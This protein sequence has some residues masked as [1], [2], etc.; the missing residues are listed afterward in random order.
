MSDKRFDLS[1]FFRGGRDSLPLILA[2]VPFGIVYGAMAQS[3]GLTKWEAMS[4]SVFVF[5]GSSQFIAVTLLASAAAL[6]VIA[7]TVFIVNLRHLLYAASLMPTAE[8]IP[9]LLRVPMAFWLTD[10]TYAV[11]SN[12]LRGKFDDGK[13]LYAYYIGSAVFMYVNWQLCTWIGITVGEKV[14]DMTNWGLDVAMVVAFIG[15]VVPALQRAA[16][17]ACAATSAVCI[18]LTYDWPHQTGLLFSSLMAIL[19]GI[20]VLKQQQKSDARRATHG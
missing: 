12:R 17:W 9:A 13:G 11:V 6:P 10:E 8:K 1:L 2:A 4:M 20:V 5:A 15:I 3:L 19:V 18:M 16:H 14:P 7:M